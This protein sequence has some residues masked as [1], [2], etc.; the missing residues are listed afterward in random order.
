VVAVAAG[1]AHRGAVQV[2]V[3]D[4]HLALHP[5][6]DERIV[7]ADAGVDEAGVVGDAVAAH[8]PYLA[9]C[10]RNAATSF[11]NERRGCRE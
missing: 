7:G 2:V 1:D 5:I 10:C 8:T 6:R 11:D 4:A 9:A 3:D